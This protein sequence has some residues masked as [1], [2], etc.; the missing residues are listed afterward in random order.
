MDSQSFH[1]IASRCFE[2]VPECAFHVNKRRVRNA[3]ATSVIRHDC[4]TCEGDP[5]D[6]IW[7][8]LALTGVLTAADIAVLMPGALNPAHRRVFLLSGASCEPLQRLRID[9][10][11]GRARSSR[12]TIARSDIPT[13]RSVAIA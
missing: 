8:G 4:A 12:S 2:S 13:S 5:G 10:L 7:Q 3:N 6:L 11:P 9:R 1:R